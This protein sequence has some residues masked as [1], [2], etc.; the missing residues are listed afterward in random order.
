MTWFRF[1]FLFLT[2]WRS[3][4]QWGPFNPSR[5]FLSLLFLLCCSVPS[6]SIQHHLNPLTESNGETE[7]MRCIK[8]IYLTF[9][10]QCGVKLIVEIIVPF[11]F[12]LQGTLQSASCGNWKMET[13]QFGPRSALSVALWSVSV[14]CC[15]DSWEC[16]PPKKGCR[17]AITSISWIARRRSLEGVTL[18]VRVAYLQRSMTKVQRINGKSPHRE[19]LW[20]LCSRHERSLF[21]LP[22]FLLWRPPQAQ[23]WW[24]G[25]FS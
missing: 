15:A 2:H 24:A 12:G 14:H 11:C 4:L 5:S 22:Q 17:G 13:M 19:R 3:S 10:A 9:R 6:A 23:L 25:T 21:P 16:R 20:I 7:A 18:I 8:N 1:T